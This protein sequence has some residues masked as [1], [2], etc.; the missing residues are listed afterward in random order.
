[1]DES[2]PAF[3]PYR[4]KAVEPL[5]FTTRAE[6]EAVLRDAG[7]NLFRVPADKVLIDLLTDSGTSAMSAEM[8]ASLMRGDESY[9]GSRSFYALERAVRELT[10]LRHV[11]PAHQGRAAERVLFKAAG[12]PGKVFLS[13]SHFD[14]TRAAVA[15]S[16]AEAVD[17]PVPDNLDPALA[18]PFKGDIDLRALEV[19]ARELGSRAAMIVMTLTNNSAGGQPA[20]LANLRAAREIS[21]HYRIPLFLDASRFA[22]NAWFIKTRELGNGARSAADIARELFSYCD[23]AWM[24]AKKDAFVSIGGFLALND[25]EWAA[26]AK[27]ELIAAEGF[28]TYG[29]LA[30]R[31]LEALATGLEEA[32]DERWLAYRIASVERF[33]GLLRRAGVPL[34]EPPGGHAAFVDAGRLLPHLAA[35][36]RPAQALAAEIYL[37]GGVRAASFSSPGREWVR[38]TVPRRAYTESH[39]AHA[40]AVVGAVAARARSV[41]GLRAFDAAPA[42]PGRMLMTLEPEAVA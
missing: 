19:K 12:G 35:A 33:A 22:E 16:G 7:W 6:R 21:K 4:I 17:L 26:R 27:D 8:W 2:A 15:S 3:E 36:S 11:L 30:G 34:V 32:V 9:A 20:S 42:G 29:G 40:A 37:E 41:R 24:S 25:D 5:G 1:M 23:G 13:N 38:L 14:T 28:P 39:L 10:G 18:A 31:D